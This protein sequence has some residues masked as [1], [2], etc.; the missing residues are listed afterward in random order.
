MESTGSF[1]K[2]I[3][4][5]GLAGRGKSSILNTLISGDPNG[6]VFRA[7]KSKKAVTTK[8]DFVDSE[9]FGMNS[10]N[11]ICRFFDVPGLLGGEQTFT[12]WSKDFIKKLGTSKV[13][14]VFLVMSKDDRMD[15]PAKITWA[16]VKDLFNA[17]AP[18]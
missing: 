16:A 3:V 9:I 10:P 1:K 13:S 14:L 6:E 2:S 4:V 7:A 12:S 5:I 15:E 8:V 11:F 18:N 17:I